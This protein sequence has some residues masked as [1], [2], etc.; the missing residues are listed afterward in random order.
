MHGMNTLYLHR[1]IF[2]VT[3]N[4]KLHGVH[5]KVYATTTT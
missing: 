3:E 2:Q 4:F 1:I 5:A